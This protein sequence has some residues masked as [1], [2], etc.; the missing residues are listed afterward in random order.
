MLSRAAA[1]VYW[2]LVV[3]ALMCVAELPAI[4]LLFL[5]ERSVSNVPLVPLCLILLAPA[6][7]AGIYALRD[8]A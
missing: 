2:H 3:G 7:S 6:F 8:R 5:L 4:A 1:F